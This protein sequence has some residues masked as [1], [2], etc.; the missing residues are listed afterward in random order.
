MSNITQ[1]PSPTK[2]VVATAKAEQMDFPSAIRMLILGSKIFRVEWQDKE[3]YGIMK[4]GFLMLHKPD[5][6]FH[7]WI[8]SE[9]DLVGTDWIVI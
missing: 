4:D 5:G 7:Q 1:S 8:V 6:A 9:G 2:K 3:F